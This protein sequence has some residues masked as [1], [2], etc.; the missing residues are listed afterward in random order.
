VCAAFRPSP[1]IG[2]GYDAYVAGGRVRHVSE[3]KR[4]AGL[5]R[6][7][8][9]GVILS[10]YATLMV[11]I[12]KDNGRPEAGAVYG[13]LDMPWAKARRADRPG[14]QQMKARRTSFDQARLK[15]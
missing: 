13:A 1:A 12:L 14:P 10:D 11:E 3:T 9:A 2:K 7:L 8:Q 4:E 6:M 5:L 15:Q